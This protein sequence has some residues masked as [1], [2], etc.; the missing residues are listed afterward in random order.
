MK[1]LS[2]RHIQIIFF[3]AIIVTTG[4]AF[5]DITNQI[6]LDWDDNTYIDANPNIKTIT[7]SNLVWMFTDY[8]NSNWHPVT[9]LTYA[10]NYHFWGK[11]PFVFKFT[12]LIFH[13]LTCFVLFYTTKILVSTVLEK[14]YHFTEDKNYLIS[15][16]ASALTAFLFAIH[17]QHIESVIWISGRKD[18]L[19]SLFYLSGV[20]CYIKQR[21]SNDIKKWQYL[22]ALSFIMS[23]MSKTVAVTFPVILIIIDIYIL[24]LLDRKSSVI[25]SFYSIIKNKIFYLTVSLCVGLITVITQSAQI[26]DTEKLSFLQRLFNMSDNLMHHL[27][28]L[29]YPEK[30]SPYHPFALNQTEY[31]SSSY[32]ALI[33]VIFISI[34]T[35]YLWK[36]GQ[37]HAFTIWIAYIV[38]LLPTSGLLRVGHASVADRYAYLPTTVIFMLIGFYISYFI[39]VASVTRY[40]KAM[41]GFTMATIIISLSNFTYFYA[42]QW[43][44]D[45]NLWNYSISKYPTN[46]AVP[47]INLGFQFDKRK[48]YQ[49][50]IIMFLNALHD[51]P[52]N[53]YALEYLGMTFM[54]LHQKDIGLNYFTKLIELRPDLPIGYIHVGDYHY[55][56]NNIDKAFDFYNNAIRIS[57]TE[58]KTILRS[59]LVDMT[60]NDLASAEKKLNYLLQL[61]PQNFHAL[62]LLAQAE[63]RAQ[64]YQS[65][66]T[67]ANRML[68]LS[69]NDKT[70]RNL[71]NQINKAR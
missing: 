71:L 22:T 4:A 46:A 5:S 63:L 47:Y 24:E 67:I 38:M 31:S 39:F 51:D 19:S 32:I 54:Q 34:S 53:S 17:P 65:A 45:E 6:F 56:H 44:N 25:S 42:T 49:N 12:N 37:K 55:A 7:F 69:P 28:T 3:A 66:S 62:K 60:I 41:V 13:L 11:N 21:S 27:T 26:V 29:V 23:L 30:L 50:S 68:Q 52:Y 48:E 61:D 36:R 18:V 35:I 43:R 8:G 9:W 70:A 1:R 58:P 57:P 15:F 64:N 16:W 59:A 14:K 10:I 33:T 40:S 20:Y 2:K